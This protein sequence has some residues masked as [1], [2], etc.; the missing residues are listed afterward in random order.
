MKN[1]KTIAEI[2]DRNFKKMC[3]EI[4][5]IFEEGI[6]LFYVTE[7]RISISR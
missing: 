7:H 2:R 5:L 4:V 3:M 6:D 1:M